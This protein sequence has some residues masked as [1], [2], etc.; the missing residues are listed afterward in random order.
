MSWTNISSWQRIETNTN[1]INVDVR[2]KKEV[3][4]KSLERLLQK[5]QLSPGAERSG[6][7]VQLR[8]SALTNY[9]WGW[10]IPITICKIFYLPQ[11]NMK[12]LIEIKL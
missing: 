9:E 5:W 2:D 1:G 10:E 4:G 6:K 11:A 3:G 8:G 7:K 12:A